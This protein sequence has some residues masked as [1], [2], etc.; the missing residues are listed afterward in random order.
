M[1]I[2]GTSLSQVYVIEPDLF[3]DTRGS[4]I[5]IYNEAFFENQGIKAD[6]KEVY[7]TVSK[8]DV[9]RGMHFQTPPHA[10][11]K[12]V[13]VIEGEINDV[14]IDLRQD[15]PVYGKYLVTKLSGIN[16]KGV[17][18]APGF[19]HGFAATS[20]QA[21]VTYLQSAVYQPDHDTGIR[22]DSFGYEWGVKDPILSERDRSFLPFSS[23]RSPFTMKDEP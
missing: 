20:E 3:T 16:G 5:K 1:K 2:V 10:C 21:I 8:K 17:L 9:I 6:F 18:M 14:V 15:S 11:W 12:F 19:A 23:F 22:W 4:F 13:Y 7:Y